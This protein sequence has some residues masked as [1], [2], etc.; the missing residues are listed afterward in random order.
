M[1]RTPGLTTSDG[2][3]MLPGVA[4]VQGHG[5]S[6]SHVLCCVTTVITVKPSVKLARVQQLWAAL[7]NQRK[8]GSSGVLRVSSG[9]REGS[10][11]KR[12]DPDEMRIQLSD[13]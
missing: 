6:L 1:A 9:Q 2:N 13:I 8:R 10:S 7:R 5:S 3:E 12:Q 4:E 11:G